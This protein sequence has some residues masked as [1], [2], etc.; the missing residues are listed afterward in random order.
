LIVSP[1]FSLVQKPISRLRKTIE[2]NPGNP[3]LLKTMRGVGYIFACEVNL[4]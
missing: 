3:R 1:A 4:I 2:A